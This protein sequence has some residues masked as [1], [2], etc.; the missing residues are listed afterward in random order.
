MSAHTYCKPR[1]ITPDIY[2]GT[3]VAA[4]V[5][6]FDWRRTPGNPDGMCCRFIISLEAP[7]GP[8]NI[9][10]CIDSTH[11]MRL[12]EVYEATGSDAPPDHQIVDVVHELR[13]MTCTFSSKNIVPRMGKHAGK[14]KAVVARWIRPERKQAQ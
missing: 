5:M 1:P 14:A 7:D 9:T 6:P 13:G 4:D 10:D 11:V 12:R 8:A 2:T 3:I